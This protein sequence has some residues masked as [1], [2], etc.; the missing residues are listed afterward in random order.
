MDYKTEVF[1]ISISF[2]I[3]VTVVENLVADVFKAL[4]KKKIHHAV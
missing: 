2:V 4:D 3:I 1:K